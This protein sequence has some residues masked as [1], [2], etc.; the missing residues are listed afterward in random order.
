MK[1]SICVGGLISYA[2]SSKLSNSGRRATLRSV[3]SGSTKR[4]R[5]GG[6]GGDSSEPVLSSEDPDERRKSAAG[7]GNGTLMAS[8]ASSSSACIFI[9]GNA[10]KRGY[11]RGYGLVTLS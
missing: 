2:A 11:A 6:A 10:S 5:G 9:L 3:T 8:G 1:R 7:R 4:P